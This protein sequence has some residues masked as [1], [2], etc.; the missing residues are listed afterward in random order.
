VA[1]AADNLMTYRGDSIWP[2]SR[3]RFSGFSLEVAGALGAAALDVVA[4]R[5]LTCDWPTERGA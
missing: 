4:V 5:R 2:S 3:R 1:E